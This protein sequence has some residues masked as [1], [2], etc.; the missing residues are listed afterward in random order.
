MSFTVILINLIGSLLK[1]FLLKYL[2]TPSIIRI[3][4]R[5]QSPLYKWFNSIWICLSYIILEMSLWKSYN[6]ILTLLVSI[7]FEWLTVVRK[8]RPCL[9]LAQNEFHQWPG[10]KVHGS[11]LHLGN[12]TLLSRSSFLKLNFRHNAQLS[13]NL[14]GI[15]WYSSQ[16]TNWLS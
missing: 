12:W 5:I 9:K 4:S 16:H 8:S 13:F 15:Q 10:H 7:I 3:Y 14:A 6:F 1:Y 11:V 2:T